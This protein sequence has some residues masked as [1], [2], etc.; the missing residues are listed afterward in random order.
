MPEE[1]GQEKAYIF[2][3][4]SECKVLAS[5]IPGSTFQLKV[6]SERKLN[7]MQQ[8]CLKHAE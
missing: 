5:Q 6:L 3:D 8:S 1:S 2:L 7:M 4:L